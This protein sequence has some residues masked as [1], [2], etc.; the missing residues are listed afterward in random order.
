MDEWI[1]KMWEVICML[2]FSNSVVEYYSARKRKETLAFVITRKD[3][4][5][6]LPRKTSQRKTNSV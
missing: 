5:G 2:L 6:I 1:K 4:G 3:L